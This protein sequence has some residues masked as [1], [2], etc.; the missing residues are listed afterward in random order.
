MTEAPS[1]EAPRYNFRETETKWQKR[2]A[3]KQVEL[4]PSL[5]TAHLSNNSATLAAIPSLRPGVM[6]NGNI[7]T[8]LDF[9]GNQMGLKWKMP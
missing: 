4:P 5:F 2:W 1:T 6:L 9:S 3:D 8:Q 7:L